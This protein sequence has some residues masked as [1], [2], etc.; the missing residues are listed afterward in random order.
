MSW[1]RPVENRESDFISKSI[2]IHGNLYDYSKIKYIDYTTPLLIVC[3]RCGSEFFQIPRR[4]IDGRGCKKCNNK[5]RITNLHNRDNKETFIKKALKIHKDLFSYENIIYIS[6]LEKVEILCKL[7]NKYFKQLPSN[8]LSG[9]G[10]PFCKASRSSIL[11]RYS[12]SKFLSK[13]SNSHLSL[14]SYDEDNFNERF[15]NNKIK[16]LCNRCNSYFSSSISSHL[17]G[18]GCPECNNKR[19]VMEDELH[20]ELKKYIEKEKLPYSIVKQYKSD[21]LKRQMIDLFIPE[22]NIG[23]EYQGIQH[24]QPVSRFGGEK[25]YL[26]SIERDTRKNRICSENNLRLIYFTYNKNHVT[27]NYMFDVITNFDD[28]IKIIK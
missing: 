8:H 28:L 19:G 5:E 22:L 11:L 16:I 3:N 12:F 9:K 24:F 6:S 27:E 4:H 15:N 25:G 18:H 20:D 21:F 14:Y 7:C 10:C 2:N 17:M 26:E 23:I 1:I 13:L